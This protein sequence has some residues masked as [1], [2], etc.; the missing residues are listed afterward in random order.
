MEE[1]QESPYFESRIDLNEL[2]ETVEQIKAEVHKLVVGQEDML[3][4][5]IADRKSVV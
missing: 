2:R 5:L 4:L 1:S 3:D